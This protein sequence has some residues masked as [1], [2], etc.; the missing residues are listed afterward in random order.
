MLKLYQHC[1]DVVLIVL[2]VGTLDTLF[3]WK[4]TLEEYQ[5]SYTMIPIAF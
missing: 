4:S 5:K 2:P 3:F 1:N